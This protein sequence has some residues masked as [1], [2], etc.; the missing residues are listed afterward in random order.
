MDEELIESPILKKA[1]EI[2]RLAYALADTLAEDEMAEPI[3]EQIRARAIMLPVKVAGIM[4]AE[5]YCLKMENAVILKSEAKDLAGYMT[6]VDMMELNAQEYTNLLRD[7]IEEFRLLFLEWIETF[8][9]SANM[10]D[11]WGIFV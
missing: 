4:G 5:L 8:D 1:E 9:K 3:S 11:G 6:M 7:T 2:L 10:D